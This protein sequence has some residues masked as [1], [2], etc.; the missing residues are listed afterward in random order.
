VRAG[1]GL[2]GAV[3]IDPPGLAAKVFKA[4]RDRGVMTRALLSS[5]AV[6]PPLTIQ[7]PELELIGSTLRE[8]LDAVA[9]S[10]EALAGTPGGVRGG[11]P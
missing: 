10:D 1:I 8:A 2:L 5:V 11:R 3:E 7:Q 4:A 6:S 9:E